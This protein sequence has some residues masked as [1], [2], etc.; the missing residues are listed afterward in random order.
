MFKNLNPQVL[1]VS[2]RQ[3]E[4]IELALTYGFK[5]LEIDMDDFAKRVES[6]GFDH[7]RRFLE[8]A[9][10]T[11]KLRVGGFPLPIDWTGDDAHFKGQM[12]RLTKVAEAAQSI[13][14]KYCFA[15]IAPANDTRPYH[16]NFELHRK[17]L[18]LIAD[19]L[20]K[21]GV[22][23]GVGVLAAPSHRQNKAHQFVHKVEELL[24]LLKSISSKHIG[25]LLDTWN[26][27]VGDGGFDQLEDLKVEQIV[28]V[29]LADL[30]TDHDPANLSDVQRALPGA[31]GTIDNVRTLQLLLDRRFDGPV[32]IW[33]SS[34]Q[35]AG[36]TREWIV[37]RVSAVSD[38]LWAAIGLAKTRPLAPSEAMAVEAGRV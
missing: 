26:W 17:R 13:G 37:Q 18:A 31:S 2:G 16:E 10:H 15:T 36:R 35:F 34:T 19:L 24:T 9:R 3:S 29:R 28:G 1:G 12:E 14:A 8:S 30:P 23:L 22:R 25:L 7:A 4:L 20:G 38:E 11:F 6:R 21:H 5:G 27:H 33:P 32:S